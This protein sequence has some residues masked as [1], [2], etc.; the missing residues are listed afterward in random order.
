MTA[1]PTEVIATGTSA[2][3]AAAIPFASSAASTSGPRRLGSRRATAI[4]S[5][6][7]P[8]WIRRETSAAIAS[9]SARVPAE[10][11]KVRS[12]CSGSG[13]GGSSGKPKPRAS[14]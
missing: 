7:T 9:A 11:R 3:S 8:A 5:G 12:E 14:A 2:S 6:A 1:P 10:R 13:S 4:S